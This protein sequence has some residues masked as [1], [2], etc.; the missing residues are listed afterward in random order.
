MMGSAVEF[1]VG[2]RLG[3][4]RGSSPLPGLAC[5]LFLSISCCP[6]SMAI[7]TAEALRV[8]GSEPAFLTRGYKRHSLDRVLVLA[9]GDQAPPRTTGDEAQLLLQSRL[10]AVGISGDR[11]EAGRAV[12]DLFDPN[13]FILDDGFQHWRLRRDCDVV[14]IDALDPLSGG[15]AFP[16]GR[17]R[18]SLEALER[19]H[20]GYLFRQLPALL[21]DLTRRLLAAGPA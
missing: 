4:L 18:E 5:A 3:S 13:V 15:A 7:W 10:G 9:P 11:S 2:V 8:T 19:A 1:A 17:Q 14:M 16:L 12:L 6:F 21:E 20:A